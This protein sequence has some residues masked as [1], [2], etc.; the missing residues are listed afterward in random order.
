[1]EPASP[2]KTLTNIIQSRKTEKVLCDPGR[3]ADVPQDLQ[4][5]YQPII[6]DA[7][8][9]AGWA[10]FHYPRQ[11]DGLAEPWRAHVL[12]SEQ[13]QALAKHLKED[14]G[15]ETKE[16]LLCAGTHALV[17]ITWIPEFYGFEPVTEKQRTRDEEHLAA[18][19]AMVQN[20]LLLLTAENLG[21][22]WSSGGILRTPELLHKIGASAGERFLAGIFIE[23]PE[24][25]DSHKQRKPGSLRD[26]R[27]EGWIR[28]AK[29]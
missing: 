1:M 23:Y 15:V 24:I 12:W 7:L 17:V 6:L 8:K 2:F 29:V 14:L 27:S 11:V 5:R 18:A 26:K 20:F 19:S 21:S 28:E 22:Y 4:E 25:K 9:T 3:A 13:V 16:P 10:P